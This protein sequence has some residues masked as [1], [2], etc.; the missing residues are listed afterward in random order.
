VRFISNAS[1]GKMGY[2][3]ARAARDRGAQVIL[4]SGP[5]PLTPPPYIE[6]VSVESALDMRDAVMDKL[7]WAQVVIMSAAVSDYR[8]RDQ[9]DQKLKKSSDE[10]NIAL[11]RNPDILAEIG[12]NKGDRVLIGFAAETENLIS[13]A[14]QKLR[15][16]NLDMVIA[17]N[18]K[19]EGSGFGSD[20]NIVTL[21]DRS[22]KAEKLPILPKTEV[23]HIVIDILS[24]MIQSDV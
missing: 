6:F 2:A 19:E 5:S 1:S 11:V 14:L 4:I 15:S 16:K 8:P 21:I 17:N 13:N 18:V 24:S 23:A 22:G 3:I 9:M 7:E 12:G 20:T 10:I